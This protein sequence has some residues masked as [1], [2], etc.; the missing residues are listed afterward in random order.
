[1]RPLDELVGME[2][3]MF[4]KFDIAGGEYDALLGCRRLLR[5]VEPMLAIGV[6]HRPSN[7]WEVPLLLQSINPHYRFHLSTEGTD[8][9]DV[10]CYAVPQRMAAATEA[11]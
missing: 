9:M 10:I 1:M 11:A 2:G 7:L 6:S 3:P 4:I 8:G 5:E